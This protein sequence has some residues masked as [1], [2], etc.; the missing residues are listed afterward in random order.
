[1]NVLRYCDSADFR[2]C[3]SGISLAYV[4]RRSGCYVFL[5]ESVPYGRPPGPHEF[6]IPLFGPG[7]G[8]S[9]VL[10][11]GGGDWVVVDSCV[12]TGTRVP[13]A[14]AY[15]TDLDI[16]AERVRLV[17]I[18]HWHDDHIRG[19]S[20]IVRAAT[21]AEVACSGA[22]R[23][24]EF[25][26][27][28]VAS[29]AVKTDWPG[30]REFGEVFEL[31]ERRLV[32]RKV[33]A[34]IAGLRWVA[35]D[36]RLFHEAATADRPAAE[37]WA[38]SPSSGSITQANRAIGA[39]LP[40]V[41]PTR[42][43]LEPGANDLA[44]AAWVEVGTTR[45]LL[46]SDLERGGNP[47][48]GWQAVIG[49]QTRP[50]GQAAILKVPHH[51]SAGSDDPL[52]WTTL[53]VNKP[54]AILTPYSRG[55]SPLPT[56]SDV[57]RITANAAAAYITARTGGWPSPRRDAAVERTLKETVR[58]RKALTGPMGHVR[59]R[60]PADD[61]ERAIVQLFNGAFKL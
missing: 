4:R 44:V 20:S 37:V 42:K 9:V 61:P 28:A 36:Q 31:V 55:V 18:T 45:I 53:L 5:A 43:V 25:F 40:R 26:Q 35:G 16:P 34:G 22:L 11:V 33:P 57:A 8:E 54:V 10:H 21:G 58:A 19:I 12:R 46:G 51:G 14:L 56:P 23:S 6:E 47:A 60:G 2:N 48:V 38:L 39:L 41:G 30:A 13:A 29:K 32:A 17:L 52:L 49:S 59:V 1:M 15:L 7:V 50:P 3:R 24:S 27:L